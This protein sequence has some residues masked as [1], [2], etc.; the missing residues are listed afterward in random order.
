MIPLVFKDSSEFYRPY[1]L[2]LARKSFSKVE[3]DFHAAPLLDSESPVQWNDPQQL[4][5]IGQY[6]ADAY[7][8]FCRN[9]WRE[10]RAP[11]DKDLL[12]YY[13]WLKETNGEGHGYEREIFAMPSE[14]ASIEE[15]SKP[16]DICSPSVVSKPRAQLMGTAV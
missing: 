11:Q 15:P 6:A 16:V 5:G 2:N 3:S 12:K 8:L 9:K 1:Y 10:M 13:K 7:N 4:H 14:S